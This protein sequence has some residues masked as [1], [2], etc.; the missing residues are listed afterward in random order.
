SSRSG[1]MNSGAL[2]AERSHKPIVRIEDWWVCPVRAV[3]LTEPRA[4]MGVEEKST[5][6]TETRRRHQP[7]PV[8]QF[9]LTPQPYFIVAAGPTQAQAPGRLAEEQR[10]TLRRRKEGLKRVRLYAWPPANTSHD[11]EASSAFLPI[12]QR[13]LPA[14][15]V[16][17]AP[18]TLPDVSAVEASDEWLRVLARTPSGA[19]GSAFAP[20]SSPSR[21]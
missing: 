3:G 7:P 20:Q 13:R 15:A 17:V 11:G 9:S 12:Q 4:A 6:V 21:Q 18:L 16:L 2:T 14:A 19:I 1:G 10:S 8:A 5:S